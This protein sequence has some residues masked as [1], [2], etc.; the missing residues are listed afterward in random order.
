MMASGMNRQVMRA[1]V[2]LAGLAVGQAGPAAAQDGIRTERIR[3][4][5]GATS[6]VVQGSI[7]GYEIVDYLIGAVAGQYAQISMQTDN[8]ASYFNILPPGEDEVAMFIGSISGNQYEGT[9]TTSGEFKLRVYMMRSAA[10]RDEVANYRLEVTIDAAGSGPVDSEPGLR[11][12]AAMTQEGNDRTIDYIEFPVTDIGAAKEFYSGVFGWKMTDYGP[13]YTSFEDG[14]LTGGFRTETEVIRGGT[15]VVLYSIDLEA[16]EATIREH[17]GRI[18][19]EIFEF[20]GGRRFHF[21]DPSGNELAV[22]SDR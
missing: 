21:L 3:F 18:V 17:G 19:Q 4:E 10:R 13:D 15:L 7:T 2:L 22:W 1:G 8:L 12:G 14:R 20:P 6:A 16:I 9:L 11:E 5:P